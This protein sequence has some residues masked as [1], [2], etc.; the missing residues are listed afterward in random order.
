[1]RIVT[2]SPPVVVEPV[3]LTTLFRGL[4]DPARFVCLL[5]VREHACTVNDVVR[6]TGLSQPNVSKHLACLRDCG[7][8]TAR[9]AGRSVTY[10]VADPAVE[11]LLQAAMV[12]LRHIGTA[13]AACPIYRTENQA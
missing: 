1:M 8:V 9:R 10:E 7:L 5:T 2:I 11:H 3:L 4:A 6:Q 12:L 13:V